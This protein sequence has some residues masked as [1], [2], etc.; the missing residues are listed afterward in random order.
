MGKESGEVFD[1]TATSDLVTTGGGAA[2][3]GVGGTVGAGAT[4]ASRG[5]FLQFY[6]RN[7]S[8]ALHRARPA[9]SPPQCSCAE[10]HRFALVQKTF[11]KIN[12]DR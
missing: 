4:I 8:R 12:S 6:A 1:S 2:R 11:F 7:A 9:K 10:K 5:L 3:R